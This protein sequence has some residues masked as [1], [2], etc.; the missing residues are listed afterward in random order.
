VEGR[1]KG[2]EERRGKKGR[3]KVSGEESKKEE[4]NEKGEK[5][6]EGIL[7]VHTIQ[8][9][10]V[11]VRIFHYKIRIGRDVFS[12]TIQRVVVKNVPA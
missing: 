7:P 10:G 9:S 6:R 3:K 5:E 11:L 12:A 8:S 2:S 4:R 1:R